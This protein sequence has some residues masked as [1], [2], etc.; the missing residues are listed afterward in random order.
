MPNGNIA[1]RMMVRRGRLTEV[2]CL[3]RG[4]S[5]D[6]QE[7]YGYCLRMAVGRLAPRRIV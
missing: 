5:W 3:D 2:D 4:G 1:M 7:D 6:Q